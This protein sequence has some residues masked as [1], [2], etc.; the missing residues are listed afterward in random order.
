MLLAVLALLAG[1]H[2]R[3]LNASKR[4]PVTPVS[5]YTA[6]HRALLATD[7]TFAIKQYE[8]LTS[9]FPF[10]S[11]ARQARLDLIYAYYRRGEKETAIDAADEFLRE[12]P[13]HPRVDY[14]WYMKGMVDFERTPNPIEV[15]FG[16]DMAKRPP[17]TALKAINAFNTVVTQYPKSD[18][19]H[20]ALR[21]MV[22]LRNRLA[23]YEVNVARY[24][25]KRGAYLAAAQRAQSVVEQYDGAPAEKSA[26]EVLRVSYQH[27]GFNDLAANVDRVYQANYA[28]ADQA[29]A[30]ASAGRHWWKLW[31]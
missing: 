18:Y 21:R 5:L 27:L 15:F 10:T 7:Y 24:Y 25:I 26:L 1:C 13:T 19:A 11:Q 6:A 31:N 30:V 3:P 12:N 17:T 16:V 20:D 9:R 8:T 2:T 14:A 22:Y 28:A 4:K 29:A 23:E